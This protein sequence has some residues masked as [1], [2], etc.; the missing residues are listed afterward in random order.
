MTYRLEQI[1]CFRRNSFRLPHMATLMNKTAPTYNWTGLVPIWF[2]TLFSPQ[3]SKNIWCRK[4]Y[5]WKQTILLFF[6]SACCM[7]IA[8][9]FQ[10]VFNLL[11][12]TSQPHILF[13]YLS[14]KTNKQTKLWFSFFKCWWSNCC[15]VPCIFCFGL[16]NSHLQNQETSSLKA[17][18]FLLIISRGF[19]LSLKLSLTDRSFDRSTFKKP[20]WG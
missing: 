8:N 11:F 13:G 5:C 14:Q 18:Y 2:A 12:S 3:P 6:I 7:S 9:V 20:L 17:L 4:V 10:K 19:V 1:H 15:T 16:P